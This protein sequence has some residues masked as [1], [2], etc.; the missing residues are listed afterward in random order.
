MPLNRFSGHSSEGDSDAEDAD[1]EEGGL[2][3][4]AYLGPD[5]EDLDD[6]LQ[7]VSNFVR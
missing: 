4:D 2:S 1:E 7:Q 5:F 6:T 3:A